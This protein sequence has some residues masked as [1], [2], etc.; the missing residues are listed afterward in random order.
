M[1]LQLIYTSAPR[2]VVAGRS[3]YCTVARS[4]TLREAVTLQLEKWSRLRH[5]FRC[6]ET[7]GTDT[8]STNERHKNT[9][10]KHL[11]DFVVQRKRKGKKRSVQQTLTYSTE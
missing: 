4:A 6:F 11:T 7:V 2:G 1:P 9:P 8:G 10:P 3:G 5:V